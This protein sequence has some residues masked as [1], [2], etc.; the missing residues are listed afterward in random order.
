MACFTRSHF[1]FL[2][3]EWYGVEGTLRGVKG[4]K[5][6]R[7]LIYKK[8]AESGAHYWNSQ[9]ESIFYRGEEDRGTPD[10]RVHLRFRNCDKAQEFFAWLQDFSTYALTHLRAF[11]APQC[12]VMD[13]RGA[14]E[15]VGPFEK[16]IV[17]SGDY[18]EDPCE[19]SP[20][21]ADTISVSTTLEAV[22]GHDDPLFIFQSVE[23]PEVVPPGVLTPYK[24][25]IKDS[26]KFKRLKDNDSNMISG[27]WVFH[28]LLDGFHGDL[29]SLILLDGGTAGNQMEVMGEDSINLDI[30]FL[31]RYTAALMEH[32]WK[33][34]AQ[35]ISPLYWRIVIHV[36][37]PEVFLESIAWKK[38]NTNEKWNGT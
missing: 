14:E 7:K 36:K 21:A 8:G 4:L 31:R 32:R 20:V 37:E 23:R 24:L 15:L 35:M 3:L 18:T 19:D 38:K 26:A 6:I 16:N 28:H 30:W 27:S 1:S 25:H 9:Q 10:L 22:V 13:A 11:V 33:N 5:G 34:G 2:C 17:N 29:P 12:V